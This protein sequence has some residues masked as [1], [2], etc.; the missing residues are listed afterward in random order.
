M[1]GKIGTNELVIILLVVVIVFGPTQLPKLA[2][3]VGETTRKFKEGMGE[4][5][6]KKD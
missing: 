5:P 4:D 3:M 1:F 6:N 2:K